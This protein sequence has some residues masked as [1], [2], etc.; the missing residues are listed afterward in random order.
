MKTGS[1]F[2]GIIIVVFFSLL[3]LSTSFLNLLRAAQNAEARIMR[4]LEELF[5]G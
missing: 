2:L 3:L 4:V 1:S 5:G